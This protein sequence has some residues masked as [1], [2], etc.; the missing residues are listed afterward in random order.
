[1]KTQFRIIDTD[2][3]RDNYWNLVP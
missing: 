1:M 2:T 3:H